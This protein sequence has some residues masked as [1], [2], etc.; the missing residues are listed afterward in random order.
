MDTL[1]SLPYVECFESVICQC[2]EG[3][4]ECIDF[5]ADCELELIFMDRDPYQFDGGSVTID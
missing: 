3:S 1:L 4:R 2:T 5:G